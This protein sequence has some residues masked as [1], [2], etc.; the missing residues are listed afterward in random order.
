MLLKIEISR[1]V[2]ESRSAVWAFRASV[3]VIANENLWYGCMIIELIAKRP[4]L[5]NSW[6]LQHTIYHITYRTKVNLKK[7][8][9]FPNMRACF[10]LYYRFVQHQWQSFGFAGYPTGIQRVFQ[11]G[12]SYRKCYSCKAYNPDGQM[13]RG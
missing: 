5:R 10:F 9:W 12:T 11:D 6:Y 8:C 13:R 7:N 4:S 2:A 3:S 1:R